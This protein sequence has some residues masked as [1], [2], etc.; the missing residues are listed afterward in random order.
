MGFLLP[1]LSTSR[2]RRKQ[3]AE[4]FQH[5][6]PDFKRHK[7]NSD[8]D[9]YREPTTL[10]RLPTEVMQ[11]IFIYSHNF[12]LPLVCRRFNS[13]LRH[14]S[15]LQISVLAE[16][17]LYSPSAIGS[18]Y[19][20]RFI[21]KELIIKAVEDGHV[22][23]PIIEPLSDRLASPPYTYEK[24]D[25]LEYLVVR[26]GAPINPSK[27]AFLL[28]ESFYECPMDHPSERRIRSRE[29]DRQI[30]Q[31][32]YSAFGP[33]KGTLRQQLMVLL[34]KYAKGLEIDPEITDMLLGADQY[35]LVE[36][37]ITCRAIDPVDPELWEKATCRGDAKAMDF[38]Y[39]MDNLL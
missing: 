22:A 28:A 13:I 12:D 29:M 18:I 27:S 4:S 21:T 10:D 37:G 30:A 5:L 11:L 2:M 25:L 26:G 32:Y 24:L 20:R 9:H 6:K 3:R 17:F 36:F 7:P 38:L 19:D 1:G 8:H 39:K 16:L 35:Q 34:M 33:H 15:Y 14:S 23:D 31:V